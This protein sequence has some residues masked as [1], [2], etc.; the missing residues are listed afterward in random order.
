MRIVACGQASEHRPHWMQIF[1]SQMGM[2]WAML[3]FSYCVVPVGNVPSTGKRADGQIVAPVGD[4]HAQHVLDERRGIGRHRRQH[5]Q[6]RGDL[7]GHLH[8]VQRR[9]GAVD[10]G[11]VPLDDRAAALL[12][13]GLLDRRP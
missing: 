7:V 13:V 8:L 5:V 6:R 1:G 2:S 9:Q 3:R 12:A 4:H 10:G 11:V